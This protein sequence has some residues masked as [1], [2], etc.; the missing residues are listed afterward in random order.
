MDPFAQA[1]EDLARERLMALFR[2][3]LPY[4]AVALILLLATVAVREVYNFISHRIDQG[5]SEELTVALNAGDSVTALI[6]ISEKD[7]D[8][9]AAIAGLTA[10]Q[11]MDLQTQK[12]AGVKL[13]QDVAADKSIPKDWRDLAALTAVRARLAFGESKADEFL[14][15]L[16]PV[17]KDEKSPWRNA[18]L[19]QKALIQGEMKKDREA[20]FE[21]LTIL[22]DRVLTPELAGQ[23]TLLRGRYAP[24]TGR[25]KS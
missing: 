22:R 8:A 12:T 2:R 19:I 25:D 21:T 1:Q 9:R 11:R 13:L 10:F 18:A 4:A 5:R 17:T 15:A 20:A 3:A 6:K 14:A 7:G 16:E 23:V 24:D